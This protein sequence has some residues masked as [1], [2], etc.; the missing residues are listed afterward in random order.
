ME[1]EQEIERKTL[2]MEDTGWKLR[3]IREEQ[4]LSVTKVAN[5]LGTSE[6]A[7]YNW[8]LGKTKLDIEHFVLLCNYYK[9]PYNE[10]I[11]TKTEKALIKYYD[12]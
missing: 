3:K 12:E 8:E 11:Q 2:N 6:Q 1:F 5:Y 4:N 7:V 9:K 10:V